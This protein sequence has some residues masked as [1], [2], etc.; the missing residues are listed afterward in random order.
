MSKLTVMV[1]KDHL[2]SRSFELNTRWISFFGFWNLLLVIIS[3]SCVAWGVRS[4]IGRPATILP[5]TP[6]VTTTVPTGLAAGPQEATGNPE[7]VPEQVKELQRKVEDLNKQ[8][9]QARSAA[10]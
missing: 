7:Q 3:I 8:L 9:E 1:F 2:A 6:A 4:L 5:F 10:A